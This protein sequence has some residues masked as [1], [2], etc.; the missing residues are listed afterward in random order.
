MKKGGLMDL[1]FQ[2]ANYQVKVTGDGDE[3]DPIIISGVDS[4]SAMA[5]IEENLINFE[6]KMKNFNWVLKLS[7]HIKTKSGK[8]LAKLTVEIKNTNEI[9]EYWF[10][11][12]EACV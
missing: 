9:K 6:M 7:E 10:D 12:T 2:F 1:E 4:I 8:H 11:I 5:A 3:S